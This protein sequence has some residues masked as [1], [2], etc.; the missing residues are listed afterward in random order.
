MDKV[1]NLR[2]RLRLVHP[3]ENKIKEVDGDKISEII[4]TR[5]PEGRFLYK[6]DDNIFIAVD[7]SSGDAWTEEFNTLLGAYLF[8]N[9][10]YSAEDAYN[11]EI[12]F[13]DFME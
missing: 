1:D 8:L 6:N 2:D 7:N 12:A 4:Q 11:V 13:D 9:E 5:K 3:N 10:G